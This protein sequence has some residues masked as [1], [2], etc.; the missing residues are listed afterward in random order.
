VAPPRTTR[1]AHPGAGCLNRSFCTFVTVAGHVAG[2]T[3]KEEHMKDFITEL[4]V[5][6]PEVPSPNDLSGVKEFKGSA[7]KR[8]I[9]RERKQRQ[10]EREREAENRLWNSAVELSEKEAR[11]VLHCRG[12]VG[13]VRN[14]IIHGADRTWKRLGLTP[15]W[16]F[17]ARGPLLQM[18][19][20]RC[21]RLAASQP[22]DELSEMIIWKNVVVMH[23]IPKS[24]K[25]ESQLDF[26]QYVRLLAYRDHWL[27][28]VE[29]SRRHEE[30]TPPVDRL[31]AELEALA[32]ENGPIKVADIKDVATG[33]RRC[34]SEVLSFDEL[35]ALWEYLVMAHP[36]RLAE[37]PEPEPEPPSVLSA[38]SILA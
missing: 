15:N 17:Y 28:E 29:S 16:F 26:M 18:V 36:V 1:S 27:G 9:D 32:A 2:T 4:E 12:I 7:H 10:R 22:D 5:S 20:R 35:R 31:T 30:L 23:Q 6:E 33:G 19:E 3:L 34:K 37:E 11:E 38:S 14:Q 8:K 13:N 21:S 25:F 24:I